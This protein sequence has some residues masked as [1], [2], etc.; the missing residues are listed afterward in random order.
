MG[1][2]ADRPDQLT[3]AWLTDALR[4]AGHLQ[5]DSRVATVDMQPIG[6]GQMCDSMRVR[7]AFDG[8]TDLPDTFV[9]KFPSTDASSVAAGK[10]MRAY[11]KEVRFYQ[12]LAHSLPVNSPAMYLADIDVDSGSFVLLLEDRSPAVQGDQI[13]GTTPEVAR[14]AVAELVQLHAPRWGDDSLESFDWMAR[15][16]R[17]QR[18][19]LSSMLPTLWQEFLARYGGAVE[20]HLRRA[21]G[22][23]VEHIANYL[24]ADVIGTGITHSDYRLDNLLFAPGVF[25]GTTEERPT[26]VDWQT[27]AYGCAP[28]DVSY[29]LG[30]SV[31]P[32]IRREIEWELLAEYHRGLVANGVQDYS[33]ASLEADYRRGTWAGMLIG[34]VAAVMVE[35]TE[36]GDTMFLTMLDRHARHALD[37]DADETIR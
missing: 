30:S 14:L 32:P 2:I 34:I 36:R 17:D 11:E 7:V 21:G 31:E 3:P 20:A 1:P 26:V 12:H 29:F 13:A 9:A 22:F 5:V 15:A 10:L 19:L 37:L 24:D 23:F 18:D 8:E 33:Q 35:R 4:T 25:A 28:Y 16:T 27:V 6:T